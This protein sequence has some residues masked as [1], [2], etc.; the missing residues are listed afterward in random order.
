M[1]LLTRR[2][3]LLTRYSERK[4][5]KSVSLSQ[6]AGSSEAEESEEDDEKDEGDDEWFH[7]LPENIL[8]TPTYADPWSTATHLIKGTIEFREFMTGAAYQTFFVNCDL[9]SSFDVGRRGRLA[10][11]SGTPQTLK[12]SFAKVVNLVKKLRAAASRPMILFSEQ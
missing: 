7:S 8:D 9:L 11:S 5:S 10:M 6:S 12:R 2:T 3:R 1:R 4:W